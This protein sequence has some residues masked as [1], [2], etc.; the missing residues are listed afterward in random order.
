[1]SF[2][3]AT[4][5]PSYWDSI[6][7]IWK[8]PR[9]PYSLP[10]KPHLVP[11][12]PGITIQQGVL[13]HA[14][15]YV[16]FLQRYY[17]SRPSISIQIPFQTMKNALSNNSWIVIEARDTDKTLIGIVLSKSIQILVSSSFLANP[18][19]NTGLV[20]LFCIAPKW[21]RNG[22][23]TAMLF[24]LHTVTAQQ[25]R[26]AHI[27][28][29]ETA[30]LFHKIPTFIRD[31]YYFREKVQQ[32]H[33]QQQ[34]QVYE[35]DTLDINFE[36]NI[37]ITNPLL[38]QILKHTPNMSLIGYNP[39]ERTNITHYT[40]DDGEYDTPSHIL[41]KPTY[42]VYHGKHVGEVIAFWSE[43]NSSD[44]FDTLLDAI[45]AFDLFL[46]PSA[47]PRTQGIPWKKGSAFGYYAFQFHPGVF[48]MKRILLLAP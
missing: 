4:N 14:Q 27:F 25:G 17:E 2:W 21:R 39:G 33:Q 3:Q 19:Q 7:S 13:H 26:L 23:G 34:A 11:R 31:T 47:F 9:P 6:Q 32:Q 38:K 29:S 8:S 24:T 16:D 5:N 10:S 35:S 30:T 22:I 40:F 1:M 45:D 28:S 44:Q 42:E 48:D 37:I 43:S 20:D 41:I 12:I 15:E 36:T 46:V 18:M